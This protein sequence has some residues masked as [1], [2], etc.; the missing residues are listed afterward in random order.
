M[1]RKSIPSRV[2]VSAFLETGRQELELELVAGESGLQK[3]ILEAALNRPGLAL[4]G[5]FAYFAYKRI[6]VLG[7]AEHAYLA[8]MTAAERTKR[9]REFFS[10]RIPCVIITRNRKIFPEF[11]ALAEEF[12]VPVLRSRQITMHFINAATI[13]MENLVAPRMTVQGTMVEIMGIGVL[14]EGKPGL[15]KSETALGLI[16]KGH[17]LVSDDVTALRLDSAGAIIATP[18]SVTRY[19]MEIRG[20]GIIHVPSLFG[21]T[22]VREEKRLDLVATLYESGTMEEPDRS[23]QFR[24][25]RQILG[26]DVPQ[27][28]IG[29]KPGRDLANLVETAA[30]DYKLRRLG[31]DA[32]KELD[33][34]LMA[35][36]SAGRAGSE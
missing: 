17:S 11:S 3:P 1:E 4:S 14:I 27:V 18:V 13:I 19:H 30:L 35:L 15:G 7:M 16:K 31:H 25:V 29:V 28:L 22:S 21:V 10:K 26:M 8:S 20:L 6:Q 9:L 34:K 36:M 12:G 24:P 5:F 33:E 32:A 23:G 2:P